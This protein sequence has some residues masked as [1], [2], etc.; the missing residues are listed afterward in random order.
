MNMKTIAAFSLITWALIVAMPSIADS[1]TNGA[2]PIREFDLK[3]IEMLGQSIYKCDAYAAR[4]TDI[5]FEKVGRPE[6]LEKEKIRGWIVLEQKNDVL[7]RFIRQVDEGFGPAY[8]IRFAYPDRGILTKATGK[9]SPDEVAQFNARQLALKNIPEFFSPRYNTVVLPDVDGKGFLVYAL[10]ATTDPDLVFIGGHYRLTVSPDGRK[11]EQVDRLFKSFLVL[12][13][14]KVPK[15]GEA[16]GLVASHVVSKTPVETHV[17]VSL[18]H[19]QPL[20][21]VTLEGKMWK[22]EKGKILKMGNKA[23]KELKATGE[24]AP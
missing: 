13:K 1:E 5:L 17:F 24:P 16:V 11:V 2:P 15:D 3:T 4:A 21:I 18:L 9:L 20:F 14:S 22:I 19:D 10:A 23:N 12:S 8:D 7:V 6:K